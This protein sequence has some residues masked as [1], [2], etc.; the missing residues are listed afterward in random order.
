[1]ESIISLTAGS[2]FK[3]VDEIEDTDT[4]L[5]EGYKEYIQTLCTA[6]ISLWLYNNAYISLIHILIILPLCLYVNQVDTLYWKTLLPLPFIT[7]LLNAHTLANVDIYEIFQVS[8]AFILTILYII[9]ESYMFPEETSTSKMIT[10][11][12]LVLVFSL[13][14]FL[15]TTNMKNEGFVNFSKSLLLFGIGYLCV[16]VISKVFFIEEVETL[17]KVD[18]FKI[19]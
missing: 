8:I 14:L 6:F 15:I 3:L 19:K 9:L 17:I 16:S 2:L 7:F 12:G 11:I 10:R 5:F 13:L 1:M 4:K 18:S